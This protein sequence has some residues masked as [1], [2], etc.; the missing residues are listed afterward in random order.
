MVRWQLAAAGGDRRMMAS[1][2]S[3]D[4]FCWQALPLVW[5]RMGSVI[6]GLKQGAGKIGDGE[7]RRIS[8]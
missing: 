8:W 1:L 7:P 4:G 6:H 3:G 2:G 5:L